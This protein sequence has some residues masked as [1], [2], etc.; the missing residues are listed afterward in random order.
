MFAPVVVINK[1][2]TNTNTEINAFAITKLTLEYEGVLVGENPAKGIFFLLLQEAPSIPRL[3]NFGRGVPLNLSL[4]R[5]SFYECRWGLEKVQSHFLIVGLIKGLKFKAH[6]PELD[7]FY[8]EWAS[9]FIIYTGSISLVI[10]SCPYLYNLLSPTT[11]V[12]IKYL[13]FIVYLYKLCFF[14]F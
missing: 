8:R 2:N 14:F 7:L 4:I 3:S 11:Q 9:R 1:T 5:T 13:I 12:P 6:P 10:Y